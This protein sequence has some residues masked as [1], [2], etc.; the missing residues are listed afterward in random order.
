MKISI[1]LEFHG[2]RLTVT[3]YRYDGNEFCLN[4]SEDYYVEIRDKKKAKIF[5]ERFK[6][7]SE[8]FEQLQNL[9]C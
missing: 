6:K 2:K 7:L 4:L 3:G 9:N 8:I 5:Y 1:E